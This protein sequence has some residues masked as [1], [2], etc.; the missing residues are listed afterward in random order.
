M[1]VDP[2]GPLVAQPPLVT[3]LTDFGLRDPSAGVLS[4]VVLSIAPWNAPLILCV[5]AL[6]MP[7]ACGNAVVLKPSEYTALTAVEL[8]SLLARALPEL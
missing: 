7:L 4:G 6:A 8:R 1:V 5:R 3:F 2:L